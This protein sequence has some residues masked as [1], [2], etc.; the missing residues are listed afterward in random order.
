MSMIFYYG[1]KVVTFI[2]V[3]VVM[4]VVSLISDK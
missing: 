2:W 3:I 4:T 1:I